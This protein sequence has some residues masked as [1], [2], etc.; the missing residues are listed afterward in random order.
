MQ[1]KENLWYRVGYALETVRT[2]LP[3]PKEG[4]QDTT[5]S[6]E[7]P[8]PLSKTFSG[9]TPEV[10]NKVLDALL[11]VGAGSILTRAVSLWP[12][13]RGPGLFRLFRAGAAGAAA[14]FL[15]EMVR[16]ALTGKKAETP[17]EEEITDV[18]LAGAGRGLLYAALVEP[19][20]PGHPVLQ[21]AVYG[22]L[23]YALSPWGGL[24]ELAGSHSPQGKIPA[25]GVLLKDRG[26]DEQL[27]EQIAFGVALA[28][29]YTH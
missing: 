8:P 9:L 11:T 3:T 28:L 12:S 2:R 14:A 27:V 6:G 29:L 4:G 26:A 20:I 23:E 22:G 16:P 17:V 15:A 13:R 5:L 10:S 21:G 25:L 24:S 1:T 7:G 18:L 19:R